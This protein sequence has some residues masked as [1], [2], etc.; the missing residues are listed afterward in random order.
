MTSGI[1]A[2]AR[3]KDMLAP[4]PALS[5]PGAKNCTRMTMI[6]LSATAANG[7]NTRRRDYFRRI[8]SS[9][10]GADR[11]RPMARSAPGRT[12]TL[13]MLS[14]RRGPATP[15]GSV[16]LPQGPLHGIPVGIK[17]NRRYRRLPDGIR[18][19]LAWWAH[20]LDGRHVGRTASRSGRR[21]LR[22]DR[23][24]R[25]RG[26]FTGQDHQPP[27]YRPHARRLVQRLG[28]RGGVG[29]GSPFGWHPDQ[30]LGDPARLVLR[31][32]RLQT[33]P[34]LDLAGGAFSGSLR[35]SIP[36]AYSPGPS[37]TSP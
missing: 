25:A 17:D 30:R 20:A 32:V 16:A 10:P 31:R 37:T 29:H 19:A 2:C 5:A 13:T 27:R 1:R 6:E 4:P 33:H 15:K 18:N 24:H 3:S 12:W 28:R 22:Q 11:P 21:H 7:K 23:N 8:G 35:L 14:N 36:S 34:R 26:L 9:L